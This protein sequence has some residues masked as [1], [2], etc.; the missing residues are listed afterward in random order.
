[1]VLKICSHNEARAPCRMYLWE[2]IVAA[3][4]RII[5]TPIVMRIGSLL[6]DYY[7]LFYRFFVFLD[8]QSKYTILIFGSN[9]FLV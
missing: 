1:M 4:V 2:Y 6:L 9:G 7:L 3:Q 8:G 5:Q